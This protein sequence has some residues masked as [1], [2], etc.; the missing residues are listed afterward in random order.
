MGVEDHWIFFNPFRCINQPFTRLRVLTDWSVE[1]PAAALEAE[2]G[3]VP[4]GAV[5]GGEVGSSGVRCHHHI[6]LVW[7][8]VGDAV[9]RFRMPTQTRRTAYSIVGRGVLCQ[10]RRTLSVVEAE[11]KS[12]VGGNCEEVQ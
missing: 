9:I 8:S 2:D 12:K 5:A 11:A 7:W 4:G 10:W 3:C 1:V 6:G